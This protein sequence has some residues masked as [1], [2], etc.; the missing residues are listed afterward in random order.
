[1]K[2]LKIIREEL[3]ITTEELSLRSGVPAKRITAIE[4]GEG[5]LRSKELLS[6]AKA[7]NVLVDAFFD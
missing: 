1:M 2:K 7:M 5:A 3:G 6:L 4:N